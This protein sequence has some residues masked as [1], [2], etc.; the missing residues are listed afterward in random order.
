MMMYIFVKFRPK[1]PNEEKPSQ[2]ADPGRV[3]NVSFI[4]NFTQ[5][6]HQHR[7]EGDGGLQ[8]IIIG[9]IIHR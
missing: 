3:V 8:K 5:Q 7:G 4:Y 2:S 6:R 9:D 1:L